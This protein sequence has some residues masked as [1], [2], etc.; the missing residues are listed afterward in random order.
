MKKSFSTEKFKRFSRSRQRYQLVRV[1]FPRTYSSDKHTNH[2][3]HRLEE[4][5]TAPTV[6]SINKNHSEMMSFFKN[7]SQISSSYNV[8]I[9][10]ENVTV[11]T[12]DAIIYMLL[13]CEILKNKYS[14]LRFNGNF[15]KDPI[16]KNLLYNSGFLDKLFNV[17]LP[18]SERLEKNILQI[19]TGAT[20]N[21]ELAGK[22]IQFALEC[23][24]NKRSAV[25]SKSSYRNIIESMSNTNNHAYDAK[26]PIKKW[27]LMALYDKENE[28]VSFSFL[29][30]G[31]G[32]IATVKKRLFEDYGILRHMS[33]LES[34]LEGKV[35]N[36]TST[37]KMERGK[38]LPSI[39]T[40]CKE[41]KTD[42]LV[43]IANKA[44]YDVKNDKKIALKHSFKG[45]LI[46]WDFIKDENNDKNN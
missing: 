29:D 19:E 30:S 33:V 7:I 22:V 16:A 38:G 12:T 15:P 43:I 46:S 18:I 11:V 8:Y 39:Y 35:F 34:A 24:G 45:T 25:S 5:I 42:N 28:R 27:Y 32:I 4:P 31:K 9:N 6:F 1:I 26:E 20:T 44:Y 10:M 13:N 37:D 41:G 2:T 36:R 14:Q 17:K 3:W 23:L 21:S 40:S